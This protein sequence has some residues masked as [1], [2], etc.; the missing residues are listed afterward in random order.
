[1]CTN[2]RPDFNLEEVASVEKDRRELLVIVED[3][4]DH[5]PKEDPSKGSGMAPRLT[6]SPA[7]CGLTC[8]DGLAEK[9]KWTLK[10]KRRKC[11]GG[12]G[13]AHCCWLKRT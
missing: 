13:L 9:A 6:V 5:L 1:M 12:L 11:S 4:A 3:M 8:N 10:R 2:V 7:T